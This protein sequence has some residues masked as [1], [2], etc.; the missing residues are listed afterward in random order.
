M[1]AEEENIESAWYDDAGACI[2]VAVKVPELGYVEQYW[3]SVETGLLVRSESS[4]DGQVFYRM[5]GYTVETPATPE[6]SFALPDGTALHITGR[7][8]QEG[9]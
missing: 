1:D 8:A 7:P 2:C 4:K 5:S 9:A 3:V 6:Q